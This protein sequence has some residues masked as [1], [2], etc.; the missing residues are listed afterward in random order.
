[1]EKSEIWSYDKT[2][3]FDRKGTRWHFARRDVI[4]QQIPYEERPFEIYFRDDARTVF[5]ALRFDR[6][7]DNPF[8]DYATMINKIMNEEEFR[9][10]L[11]DEDT[12]QLWKRSWK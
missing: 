2:Q 3:R 5:G 6:W 8:R 11:L 10:S 1:M 7:K 12:K 9:T 4:D